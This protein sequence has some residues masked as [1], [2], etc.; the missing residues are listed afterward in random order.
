MNP[1]GTGGGAASQMGPYSGFYTGQR[2]FENE[3]AIRDAQRRS[4]FMYQRAMT[5]DEPEY[6][7]ISPEGLL[8]PRLSA[9][10]RGEGARQIKATKKKEKD[11]KNKKDKDKDKKT[12]QQI[13]EAVAQG[14]SKMT[15]LVI[16]VV[17]ATILL[18]N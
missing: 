15:L 13:G 9:V 14:Q 16:I 5:A 11:D 6:R 18:L 12:Q 8:S 2:M 4:Q 17:V 10:L 3:D 1:Y 7:Y